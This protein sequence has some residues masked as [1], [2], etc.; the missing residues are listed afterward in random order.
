MIS[1]NDKLDILKKVLSSQEFCQSN[2]TQELLKYLVDASDRENELNELTI[3]T[4]F[5]GKDSDFNPLEDAAIRVNISKIRRRLKNYYLSEGKNDK[6]VI[7]L[8]KGHYVVHFR[9]R[10][11][12][13]VDIIKDNSTKFA[14]S[15]ITLLLSIIVIY[16]GFQNHNLNERFE[17]I[18]RDNPIWAEYLE[19]ERPTLVV[20]GD[21]F[22]MYYDRDENKPRFNVRDPLINSLTD[23]QDYREAN[24]DLKDELKPL[25]HTY[26]RP[27]AVWGF[28]ELQPI[29]RSA[30]S[31][32]IVKQAS[33]ITWP[34]ISSHN[35]I[36]I[37]T[38]KQLYLFKTLLKN[39]NAEFSLNP[40]ILYL[41]NKNGEKIEKFESSL[42]PETREYTDVCFLTKFNGPNNNTIMLITGFN[43]G[44]VIYGSKAIS[45]PNFLQDIL[46]E[47][48]RELKDPFLFKSVFK[49]E[50]YRRT[51]LSSKLEYFDVLE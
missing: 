11:E 51:E 12:N 18:P 35:V 47:Y 44:G 26:L 42:D 24:P 37:G 45:N 48:S 2:K 29:L 41:D 32:F 5:F 50:G 39:L 33:E 34:D 31:S 8:P 28:M 40:S 30:K 20:L 43:E 25:E 19:D 16:L 36:F 27:S 4:E 21:Y 14:F 17:I 38:F 22:F 49:V 46:K 10:N 3:A 13:Y 7:D 15:S 23:Y 1:E 9:K 6:I